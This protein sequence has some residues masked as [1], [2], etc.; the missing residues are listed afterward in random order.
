M[1]A[2]G[3]FAELSAHLCSQSKTMDGLTLIL[4]LLI[5]PLFTSQSSAGP[6]KIHGAAADPQTPLLTTF[7]C[8]ARAA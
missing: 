5:A 6:D 8:Y 1:A 3:L 4:S 2:V 7:A